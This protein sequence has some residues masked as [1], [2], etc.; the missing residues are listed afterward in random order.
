MEQILLNSSVGLITGII[1][2]LILDYLPQRSRKK[3]IKKYKNKLFSRLAFKLGYIFQ[4]AFLRSS[5]SDQSLYKKTLV[6]NV[7]SLFSDKKIRRL[8]MQNG[9]SEAV[10]KD[11]IQNPD[12]PNKAASEAIAKF[13][14]KSKKIEKKIIQ[15]TVLDKGEL[16]T[17]IKNVR[18]TS[19]VPIFV[20]LN[21]NK[22][23]T[24]NDFLKREKNEV[25]Q[26]CN[27][28]FRVVQLLEKE[29][30]EFLTAVYD[31]KFIRDIDSVALGGFLNI[32]FNI[33]AVYEFR[34]LSSDF[35]D[36]EGVKNGQQYLNM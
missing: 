30:I 22:Y 4:E 25:I 24:V 27:N 1:L 12:K 17:I 15:K 14:T 20:S 11:L 34:K 7:E 13:F 21:S 6:N 33:D 19:T 8:F 32:P 18:L 16:E 23:M 28:L 31:S 36:I 29:E 35:F 3:K 10:I 26:I 5:D 2:F 9:I